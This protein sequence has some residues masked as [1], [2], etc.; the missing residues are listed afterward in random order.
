MKNTFKTSLAL[1]AVA[2]VTHTSAQVTLYPA[3]GFRG[4]G[5][6]V[7]QAV[8]NFDRQGFS[9]TNGS[10]HVESGNWELC[11]DR[12]FRG[13]CVALSPGRYPSLASA[14]L[15]RRVSSVRR[16]DGN[17]LTPRSEVTL[18]DEK[19][20]GG[21]AVTTRDGLAGLRAQ[22]FNDRA[23]SLVVS[24]GTWEVCENT[25]F[26]GR[27][28]TLNPGRYASLDA[29]GLTD[30]ISSLR[31]VAADQVGPWPQPGAQNWGYAE[32][33]LYDSER[34]V[35]KSMTA[36]DDVPWL[37]RENFNDLASSITI[38]AGNWEVCS[39]ARYAGRCVTLQPGQYPTLASMA[40]NDRISSV[41]RVGPGDVR[42]NPVVAAAPGAIFFEQEGLRGRWYAAHESNANFDRAGLGSRAASVEVQSGRWDVCEDPRFGGKCV[43]LQ[44]GRYPSIASLTLSDRIAS[45]R[46]FGAD[47]R[48]LANLEGSADFNAN[49][50]PRQGAYDARRRTNEPLYEAPIKSVRQVF[51]SGDQQ[52]CYVAQDEQP[53]GRN[54]NIGGAI[55]GALLGGILG[56][57]VGGGTGKDVA[58]AGGAIAGAV[59]GARV[60]GRM[61]D[62]RQDEAT[63]RCTRAQSQGQLAYWEVAYDFKGIE[64]RAQLTAQPGQT[65]RVNAEGEPRL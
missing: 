39:D 41:R 4:N 16:L 15:Q 14:G 45:A 5:F 62:D 50:G 56:H 61:D 10:V 7:E 19:N 37:N 64:H 49:G 20:F 44:P 47:G 35:G 60:A 40:L 31:P 22:D 2:A 12:Q 34:F 13:R 18:Y 21:G 30:R 6:R 36:R 63:Q 33:R 26:G 57:Q 46:A 25:D 29:Y 9:A 17:S 3:E 55:A 59:I 11:D 28:V 42:P 23:A 52:L 48:L 1:A 65:I 53:N 27:C 58:T 24:G 43:T 54:A 38:I 32:I 8:G 51:T